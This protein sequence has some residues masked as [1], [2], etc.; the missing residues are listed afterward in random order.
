MGVGGGGWEFTFG[1][2][3]WLEVYFVWVVVG[4]HFY[5]L[6]GIGGSGWRYILGRWGCGSK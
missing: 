6:V 4:T 1:G 2:S 3:G 5:E